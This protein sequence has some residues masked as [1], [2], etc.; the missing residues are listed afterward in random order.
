M[1]RIT[2]W[3]CP[4]CSF[5]PIT[6]TNMSWS[7]YGRKALELD[8]EPVNPTTQI[9]VHYQIELTMINNVKKEYSYNLIN[10]HACSL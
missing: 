1:H 7:C 9:K 6:S 5:L 4:P 10:N 2:P 3:K 8:F